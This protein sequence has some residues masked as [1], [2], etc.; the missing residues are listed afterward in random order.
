MST[1]EQSV[2]LVKKAF[3]GHSGDF[4]PFAYYDDSLDCI[5]LI[6]RNCSV[7]ETRVNRLFTVLEATYPQRVGRSVI[8]FTI[9]GAKHFCHMNNLSLKT[10]I[11]VSSLL[12]A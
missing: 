6:V 11:R 10:P 4:R 3:A 9:K 5:R 2:E 8:G 7:T 12:D 1:P